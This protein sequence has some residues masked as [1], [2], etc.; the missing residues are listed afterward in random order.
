MSSN[1]GVLTTVLLLWITHAFVVFYTI[2]HIRGFRYGSYHQA[3]GWLDKCEWTLIFHTTYLMLGA[4]VATV[5]I[6]VSLVLW[7]L[8]YL[9][10][11][12]TREKEDAHQ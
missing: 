10:V 6:T 5:M 9:Q 12:M 1:V 8:T 4:T 7:R 2:L 11:L 3:A